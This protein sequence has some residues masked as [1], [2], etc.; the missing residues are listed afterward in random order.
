MW[1]HYKNLAR[2]YPQVSFS[3]ER[4]LI[5]R[6]KKGDKKSA[7]QLVLRHIGFVIFRVYSKIVPH[8][9][10]R[11]GEDILSESVLILY[12]QIKNYDLNYCDGNGNLRPVKFVSYIWKRIDG[13]IIDSIKRE[14]RRER[15]EISFQL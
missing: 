2:K 3:E 14:L 12:K 1:G 5:A 6:A 8:L 13:F 7:N 4:N 10:K 15:K 11:H 9:L